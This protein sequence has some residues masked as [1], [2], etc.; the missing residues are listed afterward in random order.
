MLDRFCS[1]LPCAPRARLLAGS[2]AFSLLLAQGVLAQEQPASDGVA[3]GEAAKAIVVTGS[4]IV[5]RDYESPSPLATLSATAIRSTGEVTLEKALSMN[6]QFGLGK[7]P[8]RPDMAPADRPRS[9]CAGSVPSAI[10]C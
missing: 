4:R 7:I 1:S 3:E 9:I 5:R 10:S 6:P 8:P 2:A